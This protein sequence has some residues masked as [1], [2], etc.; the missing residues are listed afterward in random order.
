MHV[1]LM[2]AKQSAESIQNDCTTERAMPCVACL[3][4]TPL[5]VSFGTERRTGASY[6]CVFS[7]SYVY[8]YLCYAC[9]SKITIT[10]F[11]KYHNMRIFLAQSHLVCPFTMSG[12]LSCKMTMILA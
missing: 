8:S 11:R 1:S 10:L 2:A 9:Y 3:E 12:S 7:Y 4:S 5:L 6:G